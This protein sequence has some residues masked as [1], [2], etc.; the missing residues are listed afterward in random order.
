MRF[1][2]PLLLL[3]LVGCSSSSDEEKLSMS[4]PPD[5]LDQWYKPKNKRQVWLHTM[6]KLRREMLAV[7]DYAKLEDYA[8][9]EKWFKR[10]EKNY[11][12]ISEMVP[13][14]SNRIKPEV[15]TDIQ[16]SIN[17]KDAASIPK[18]LSKL[19]RTCSNCHDKFRAQVAALYRTPN[20]EDIRVQT[21]V[22]GKDQSF[23]DSMID[24]SKSINQILI[25]LDDNRKPAALAAHDRLDKQLHYMGETCSTCHKDKPPIARIFGEETQNRMQSMKESIEEDRVKDTQKLLG[26]VGVTV[27]A[28]CHMVHRSLYDLNR[29]LKDN[30]L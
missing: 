4:A 18:L 21:L 26:E 6:F 28:R 23:I 16:A 20:Y 12:K 22:A 30:N 10:F 25:A 24:T 1:I 15:L 8:A 19:E 5:S 3:A 9:L 2:L 7:E 27:C 17:N 11:N 29:A 13:E 14:W